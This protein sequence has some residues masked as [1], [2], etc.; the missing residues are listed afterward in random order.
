MQLRHGPHST[1][2]EQTL[3]PTNSQATR[4]C[5]EGRDSVKFRARDGVENAEIHW[6]S[7]NATVS[8]RSAAT[9]GIHASHFRGSNS[10]L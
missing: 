3:I 5:H 1:P 8:I 4:C 7:L 10:E 6:I 2:W 9:G